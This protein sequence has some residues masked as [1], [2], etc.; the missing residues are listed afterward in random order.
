MPHDLTIPELAEVVGRH[1]ET[2][3]RLARLN[4]LPGAYRLVLTCVS[5]SNNAS[6]RT[7]G[8]SSFSTEKA[9]LSHCRLR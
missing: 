9:P 6:A 4:R 5:P 3:R 8:P 2:L 1:P 7:G